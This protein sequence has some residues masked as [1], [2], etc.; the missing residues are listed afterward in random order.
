MSR[1][2]T[3]NNEREDEELLEGL[4]LFY[5]DCARA[6]LIKFGFWGPVK[7]TKT[8]QRKR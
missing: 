6:N 8:S 7:N 1:E 5:D 2:I 4:D 3:N